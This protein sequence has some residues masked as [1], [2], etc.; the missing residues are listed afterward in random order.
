MGPDHRA[1]GGRTR[2]LDY[3]ARVSFYGRLFAAVYDRM[4]AGTEEAGLA[5]MRREVLSHA[6]GE[7]IEIGAGTGVNLEHYGRGPA[8]LVLTEPEEPMARRLRRHAAASDVE[9]EVVQAPA[10]ALPFADDSFDTAVT[11]L[12]LC[13]VGHQGR[14]LG[15]LRRVLRP[16]G[17]LLFIEHVRSDEP[18]VARWQDR[19]HRPW[20]A[21]G[22]G[23]NCNRD[24]GGAIRR[25]G[26][27]IEELVPGNVP[28]APPIV[29]PLIRGRASSP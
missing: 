29:R 26:F 18:K 3:A 13:T 23:C 5:D 10:E 2:R 8:R 25:A 21:F 1:G 4:M 15:E 16:G 19:L 9:A 6:R 12:A 17:R 11:T 28:K 24:T 27:E 14:A 20:R 22:H 7:V